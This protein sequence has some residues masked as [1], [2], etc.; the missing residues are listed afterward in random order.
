[1]A[2]KQ[3]DIARTLRPYTLHTHQTVEHG[4]AEHR[5]PAV[6]ALGHLRPAP[7]SVAPPRAGPPIV[8]VLTG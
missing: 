5:G 3:S 8:E 2:V 4:G 6:P 7:L 1:M